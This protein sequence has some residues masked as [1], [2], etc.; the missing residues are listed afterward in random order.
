MGKKVQKVYENK[1]WINWVDCEIVKHSNKPFKSGEKV[2]VVKAMAINPHSIKTAFLMDDGS[3]VDCYQCK[4]APIFVDIETSGLMDRLDAASDAGYEGMV[5]RSRDTQN[6]TI[7]MKT[8]D[9]FKN[10][11]EELT[12]PQ[13]ELKYRCIED[14]IPSFWATW[15]EAGINLAQDLSFGHWDITE[16]ELY[17]VITLVSLRVKGIKITQHLD[18]KHAWKGL[19]PHAMK[20]FDITPDGYKVGVSADLL[21]HV[22]KERDIHKLSMKTGLASLDDIME[23]GFKQGE[24]SVFFAPA[25]EGKSQYIR[26]TPSIEDIK[27]LVEENKEAQHEDI[28]IV[29]YMNLIDPER[30]SEVTEAGR[31]HMRKISE[32][33]A[34]FIAELKA[35]G[36][37]T[38]IIPKGIGKLET[39]NKIKNKGE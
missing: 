33:M 8:Q 16:S 19:Y 13:L 29:D 5:F 10:T 32:I 27:K 4:L 11:L 6:F 28:E 25:G 37:Q 34:E 38:M 36:K 26:E 39:Y 1:D 30:A 35:K 18:P 17:R 15:E 24:L 22:A 12:R 3:I 2:G 20:P 14:K 21:A 23:G 31:G 7:K 9:V